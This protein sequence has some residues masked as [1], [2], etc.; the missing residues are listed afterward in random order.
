MAK[1]QRLLTISERD[2]RISVHCP[3]ILAAHGDESRQEV[4]SP[5][6]EL[7]IESDCVGHMDRDAYANDDERCS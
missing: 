4:I 1:D 2:L 5:V 3:S 6:S 7:E